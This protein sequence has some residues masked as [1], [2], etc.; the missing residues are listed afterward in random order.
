MADSVDDA[1]RQHEDT[2]RVLELQ[3]SFTNLD[4]PLI[5]PGRRLIKCGSLLKTCRKDEQIR[6]FF[7]FSDLIV[8]GVLFESSSGWTRAMSMT[9]LTSSLIGTNGQPNSMDKESKRL[10]THSLVA[11]SMSRSASSRSC[12]SSIPSEAQYQ[13]HR[14]M[15][16]KDITVVGIEGTYFEIRSSEK[17]FAVA[18][19]D[20]ES[21]IEWMNAIR[22]AKDELMSKRVTLYTDTI[23]HTR[24]RSNSF[25]RQGPRPIPSFSFEPMASPISE[26]VPSL[27]PSP[28]PSRQPSV[29]ATPPKATEEQVT[30]IVA[31][32]TTSPGPV[33]K[34]IASESFVQD[35][36]PVAHNYSAPVWIPDAKAS[37]CM[38]CQGAFSWIRRK[39][40]CR[41]CGQVVCW[42]CSGKVCCKFWVMNR[43]SS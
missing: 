4:A 24:T 7:L 31:T 17:S 3:R 5:A 20:M 30:P 25:P 42:S 27:T 29:F 19:D 16:L 28:A 40:H 34:P 37:R 21:K 43:T 10:S 32:D 23:K 2:Q 33:D 41:L 36:F 15:P 11:P 9:G 35:T 39:H 6:T 14:R 26:E 18:A 12:A 22:A 13:L 8:Y 1:V 38:S